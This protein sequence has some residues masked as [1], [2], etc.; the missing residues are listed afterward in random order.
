MKK[1][2]LVF[3]LF[4]AAQYA[5]AQDLKNIKINV[6]L[7]K[8]D[9]AKT[10]IDSYLADQKNAA[11]PEGWYYKAYIY[12]SLGRVATKPVAE[13][14]T[15]YQSSFDALKKYAELDPKAPL[16]AE[17]N[18]STMFNIY[19]GYYDLGVKTYNEKN[20]TESF[21]LFKKA[22]D[23]HDYIYGKPLTGP[24][25]LKLAAHDTD[26]IWNLAVLANELKKADETS[27][28]Y[29]KIA[30]ADLGDEKY[31]AAYD[32]LVL[33][34]KREKNAELFAKYNAAAKK[35]YPIDIPYWE[36]QEI[37][38]AVKD[39][40]NEALLDKYEELTKTLPNNYIVFY[41]YGIEVDKFINSKESTG[42]DIAAYKNKLLE[43]FKKA[44]SIKS[45]VEG[46]L[47]LANIY[48]SKTYDL[49]EQAA[50]IK[51]TKPAE[52]KLKSDLQAS[53]KSTMNEAIPFAEEAV[54]LLAALKEYKFA[55]KANYK[56][57]L[58]ILSNAYKMNGNAAKVAE[59]EKLKLEVEKL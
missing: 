25:N 57:A 12:N 50:K 1:Y 8:F 15:L 2:L 14:K 11:K 24:N 58:E 7:N 5:G 40:E 20:Y 59:Y 56:L 45:T 4:M 55:D 19:Y 30:D 17:E 3:T 23:V 16:T 46:N 36:A 53:I 41:N 35:H 34:Y 47:Q 18:N 39:L 54:K 9:Q 38:F 28:Y 48:Y 52:V 6:T 32:A 44:N 49:Q 29:K 43:L 13:S 27:F 31:A 42:K 51:G 37:E 22:L 21:D 10:E 33:K 26:L